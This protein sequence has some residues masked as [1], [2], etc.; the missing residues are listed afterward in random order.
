MGASALIADALAAGTGTEGAAIACSADV[1]AECTGRATT[2][3]GNKVGNTGPMDTIG[4]MS[5]LFDE[6][7]CAI[8][9]N[10]NNNAA[11]MPNVT[12]HRSTRPLEL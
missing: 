10:P 6:V 2:G 4:L 5:V 3:G 11:T 12:L 9:Q 8:V 7:T 1:S